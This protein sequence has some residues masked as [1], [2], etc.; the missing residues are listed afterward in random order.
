MMLCACFVVY[1]DRKRIIWVSK[2]SASCC[3]RLCFTSACLRAASKSCS[4]PTSA[5]VSTHITGDWSLVRKGKLGQV[6]IRH[7]IGLPKPKMEFISIF[8]L[9]TNPIPI[10]NLHTVWT[11]A[12]L[13]W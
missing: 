4:S 9:I 1:V 3:T 13:D 2:I 6:P 8:N 10:L 5:R 12:L 11:S 7:S